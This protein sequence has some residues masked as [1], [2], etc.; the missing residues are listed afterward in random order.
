VTGTAQ[1]TDAERGQPTGIALGPAEM[2]DQLVA[3]NAND[4]GGCVGLAA[5]SA[6][7]AHRL[8]EGL[9]GQLLGQLR[10]APASVEEVA[11]DERQASLVPDAERRL[12]SEDGRQ[13]RPIPG[14]RGRS[15]PLKS[16]GAGKVSCERPIDDGVRC[17]PI[18]SV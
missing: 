8:D 15:R 9:L 2:V 16:I 11:V 14:D 1:V 12:V 5:K 7:T 17:P 10:V 4:P 6:V 13:L 18:R 3:R